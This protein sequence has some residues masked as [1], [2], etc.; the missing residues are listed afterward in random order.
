MNKQLSLLKQVNKRQ[1][2]LL[3]S[4]PKNIESREYLLWSGDVEKFI[5]KLPSESKFDLV[6]TSPPPTI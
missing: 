1:V 6:V 2:P 3:S 4:M 5:D